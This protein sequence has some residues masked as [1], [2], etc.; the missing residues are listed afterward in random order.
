MDKIKSG[1][2]TLNNPYSLD[3]ENLLLRDL[4][5]FVCGSHFSKSLICIYAITTI[6]ALEVSALTG[7]IGWPCCSL[8]RLRGSCSIGNTCSP[9]HHHRGLRQG[10]PHSP[11]LFILA[12]DPLPRLSELAID[13]GA[14]SP[15]P[16]SQASQ[17]VSMFVD[18]AVL[19]LTPRHKQM[20]VVRDI[21]QGFSL[22]TGLS[23]NLTKSIVILLPCDDLDVPHIL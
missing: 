8:L 2:A 3:M 22:V 17:R 19:F 4:E 11:L 14:L 18:D 16:N 7:A 10:D 5:F 12:M 13:V 15:I 23:V 21:T 20:L 9:I 6:C 1:L